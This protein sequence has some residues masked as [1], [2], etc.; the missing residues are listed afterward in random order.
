MTKTDELLDATR[1]AGE[2]LDE[3]RTTAADG[4]VTALRELETKV[5]EAIGE[6]TL[7]GL[8]D[9]TP[10]NDERCYGAQLGSKKYGI[11]TELPDDGREVLCMDKHGVL[12]M[13]RRT[14][15][16]GGWCARVLND[17]DIRTEH[18][19]PATRAIQAILERHLQR[20]AKTQAGYE[21]VAALS[22]KLAGAIGFR[23]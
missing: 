10:G 2:R 23:L 3:V 19:E 6:D 9:L 20:T 22:S 13:M 18:L 8:V 14:R 11:D 17:E 15:T 7:R 1:A 5:Q 4:A 21:A 16:P 12:R